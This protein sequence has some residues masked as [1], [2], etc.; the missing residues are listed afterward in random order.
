VRDGY[1]L[2]VFGGTLVVVGVYFPIYRTLQSCLFAWIERIRLLLMTRDWRGA[3][4]GRWP[5]SVAWGVA[6]CVLRRGRRATVNPRRVL[7]LTLCWDE[8]I[9]YRHFLGLVPRCHIQTWRTC[10]WGRPRSVVFARADR[11]WN[12]SQKGN[13]LPKQQL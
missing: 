7:F 13:G 3:G 9:V 11:N 1:T 2:F 4:R 6:V 12:L 10:I 8:S 5:S